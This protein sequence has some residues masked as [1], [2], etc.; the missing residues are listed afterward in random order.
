MVFGDKD[1][2]KMKIV[3]LSPSLFLFSKIA[4]VSDIMMLTPVSNERKERFVNLL[5]NARELEAQQL[6]LPSMTDDL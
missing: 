1:Y 2:Q 6:P 5:N 4:I 3:F